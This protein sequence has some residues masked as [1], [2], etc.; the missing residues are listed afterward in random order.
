MANT[1]LLKRSTVANAV[2]TAGNLTSGEL[3][4]NT[5]DGKLYFKNTSNVVTLLATAGAVATSTKIFNG[6]SEANIGTAN[7]NANITIA[8]TSNVAVF[9]TA[10][11]YITGLLSVTG[12]ITGGNITGVNLITANVSIAGNIVVGAGTGTGGNLSGANVIFATTLSATGNVYGNYFIGNGSQLTGIASTFAPTVFNDV[13]TQTNGNTAVFALKTDQTAVTGVTNS[14]QLQVTVNGAIVAPY[15]NSWTWPFFTTWYGSYPGFRVTTLG[16][17]LT[18][19]SVVIYNVPA[20]SSA[21]SI[22]QINNA[23]DTQL[24]RYPYS[25]TAIGLGD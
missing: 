19:N 13:S 8:G 21:V 3:A 11:Q 9:S 2:P 17:G 6:T 22:T 4:L 10:G 1:I 14:K 12:N 5:A 16:Y 25:A 24:R 23:T 7:G 15:I 18:A 20:V